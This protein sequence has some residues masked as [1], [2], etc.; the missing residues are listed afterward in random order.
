[1]VLRAIGLQVTEAQESTWRRVELNKITADENQRTEPT[2]IKRIV[3]K[4]KK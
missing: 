2:K 3:R 4:R 1:M